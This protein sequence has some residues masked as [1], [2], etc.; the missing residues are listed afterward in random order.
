MLLKCCPTLQSCIIR[1]IIIY[2]FRKKS[3]EASECCVIYASSLTSDKSQEPADRDQN[4]FS[5]SH[6]ES[7][8]ITLKFQWISITLIFSYIKLKSSIYS[9]RW[10][11]L[12]TAEKMGLFDVFVCNNGRALQNNF[13]Q[14]L[15][16]CFLST[17]NSHKIKWNASFNFWPK[18]SATHDAAPFCRDLFQGPQ[19][20]WLSYIF[21]FGILSTRKKITESQS[22]IKRKNHHQSIQNTSSNREEKVGKL[23]LANSWIFLP[24]P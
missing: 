10:P 5:H 21:H 19:G 15:V 6:I 22:K 18:P 14:P 3:S 8:R 23:Y 20:W 24:L 2:T 1:N 11:W 4:E 9:P 7:L 13:C 12:L 17:V 16:Q